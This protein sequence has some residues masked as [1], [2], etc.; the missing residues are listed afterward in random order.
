MA[1]FGLLVFVFASPMDLPKD[2]RR[3]FE[4]EAM[5]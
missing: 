3:L 2:L 1:R 4:N 5:R